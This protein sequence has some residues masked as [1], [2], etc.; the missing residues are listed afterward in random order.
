M[1]PRIERNAGV[2]LAGILSV[3]LLFSAFFRTDVFAWTQEIIEAAHAVADGTATPLQ[4]RIA[5]KHNR[6]I[7]NMKVS[8]DKRMPNDVYQKQQAW[9]EKKNYNFAARSVT[10]FC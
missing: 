1:N 10:T 4:E 9:F 3:F 8:G 5:F 2:H 7:N 6:Q